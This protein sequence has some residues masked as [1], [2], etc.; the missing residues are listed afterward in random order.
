MSDFIVLDPARYTVD[1]LRS[2]AKGELKAL[3]PQVAVTLLKAKLGEQAAEELTALA[4]DN[5]ADPRARHAATLAL[6]SFPSA[7]EALVSLS[8][9]AEPLVAQ[10]AA[11]ALR[12]R[13]QE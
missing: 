8:S 10:A 4:R 12:V 7:R 11:E 9:S 13:R 3:K 1:E 6:A 5:A 2:A